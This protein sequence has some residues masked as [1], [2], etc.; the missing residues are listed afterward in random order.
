[1]PPSRGRGRGTKRK[2]APDAPAT[3][4]PGPVNNVFTAAE[5]C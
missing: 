1:M 3:P 5:E 4:E 2:V